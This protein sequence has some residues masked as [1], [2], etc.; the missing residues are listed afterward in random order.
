MANHLQ[1]GYGTGTAMYKST[2]DGKVD[3]ERVEQIKTAIKVGY[4]HLDGAEVYNT[5]REL[6]A[7]IKESK[8]ERQKL[9]VTTKV[10]PNIEDVPKA[11]DASLKKLGLDYVDLFVSPRGCGYEVADLYQISHSCSLAAE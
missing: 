3:R 2:D 10:L 7:A 4:M 11:L 8:V 1:L 9:F 5:E 6:G